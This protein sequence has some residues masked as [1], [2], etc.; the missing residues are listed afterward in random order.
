MI[1]VSCTTFHN[2]QNSITEQTMTSVSI[3][4]YNNPIGNDDSPLPSP[5]LFLSS[6]PLP[7]FLLDFE[8]GFTYPRLALNVRCQDDSEFLTLLPPQP[9]CWITGVHWWGAGNWTL[10]SLKAKQVFYYWV[11]SLVLKLLP[12]TRKSGLYRKKSRNIT[13]FYFPLNYISLQKFP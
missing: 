6:F 5:S 1:T 9:E 12:V 3:T 7:S 8:T 11:S 2:T 10:G 13:R 4:K